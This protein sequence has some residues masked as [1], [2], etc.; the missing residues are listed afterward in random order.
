MSSE[1][2]QSPARHSV[3]REDVRVSTDAEITPESAVWTNT[4]ARWSSKP[5]VC[6]TGLERSGR[7]PGLTVG[8]TLRENAVRGDGS[9]APTRK[10]A[11][12]IGGSP[13]P[14][15]KEWPNAMAV[16]SQMTYS[17]SVK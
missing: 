14:Y 5:R 10:D 7:H 17:V 13:R 3:H 11:G 9:P 16:F 4:A 8:G 2:L 6:T 1:I 15:Q 12:R